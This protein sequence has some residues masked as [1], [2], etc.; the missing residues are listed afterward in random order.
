VVRRLINSAAVG[1]GDLV[2]E[3]GAGTG[4]LTTALSRT[5]ARVIAVERN[6]KF[7]TQLQRRF[8]DT[9]A[10]RIVTADARTVP[11]PRRPFAVV[12]NIPYS[13]STALLRRLLCARTSVTSIDLL[14]EWGFAKRVS[15][16]SPRDEETAWWQ[17][18]FEISMAGRVSRHSFAPAPAVDSAHLVIRRR[19]QKSR[20]NPRPR[21]V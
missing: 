15:A 13:I 8:G 19:A 9:D 2:L 14:V 10:V 18:R 6:A 16:P 4:V 20:Q 17:S 3:F 7:A 11:L 5:G 21:R 1:P 12:A